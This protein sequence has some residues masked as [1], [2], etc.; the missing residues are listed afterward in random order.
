LKLKIFQGDAEFSAAGRVLAAAAHLRDVS[1]VTTVMAAICALLLDPAL[2]IVM[3][4]GVRL[5]RHIQTPLLNMSPT[6]KPSQPRNAS[7]PWELVLSKTC[8]NLLYPAPGV[9]RLPEV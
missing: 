7:G 1:S 5:L 3:G 8:L 9:L 2:T 6:I 4:T